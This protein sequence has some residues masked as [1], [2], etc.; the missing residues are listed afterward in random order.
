MTDKRA[1]N[2]LFVVMLATVPLP[3]VF[4]FCNGLL[5]VSALAL[6]LLN[7]LAESGSLVLILAFVA[8]LYVTIYGIF[9]YWLAG[10]LLRRL[11]AL[12]SWPMAA[13]PIGA[14][15]VLAILPV[16]TFDCMDGA[17]THWC[18]WY[19]LHGAWF[20]VTERCGDFR[21]WNN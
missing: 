14:L 20:G 8:L 7:F 2:S 16:Y 6:T 4:L 9:L 18:N 19:E 10:F 5:P 11:G 17:P 12:T 3:S 13:L 15:L 21:R 1:R